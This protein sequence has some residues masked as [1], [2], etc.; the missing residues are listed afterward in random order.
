M[1]LGEV[2]EQY[3]RGADEL[4]EAAGFAD[5]AQKSSESAASSLYQRL[6]VWQTGY[7]GL[8][9]DAHSSFTPAS[10]SLSSLAELATRITRDHRAPTASQADGLT[11]TSAAVS[12]GLAQYEAMAQDLSLFDIVGQVRKL[13]EMLSPYDGAEKVKYSVNELGRVSKDLGTAALAL[14]GVAEMADR[15]ADGM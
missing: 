5:E 4:R 8:G 10:G 7:R 6:G 13:G 12:G 14:T 15:E 2:S 11:H 1:S 9:P 3:R